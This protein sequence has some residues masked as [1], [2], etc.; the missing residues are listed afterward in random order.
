[1]GYSQEECKATMVDGEDVRESPAN[2]AGRIHN[3]S[4]AIPRRIV[5]D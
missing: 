1:M 2:R 4:M 5:R 3:E